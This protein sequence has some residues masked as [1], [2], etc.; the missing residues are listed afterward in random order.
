MYYTIMYVG[1]HRCPDTENYLL[2][3]LIILAAGADTGWFKTVNPRET[4]YIMCIVHTYICIQNILSIK[5]T[6]NIRMC[7]G[8][9]FIIRIKEQTDGEYGIYVKT[10][11]L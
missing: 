7:V 11:E 9:Y 3:L 5:R 2:V 4:L 1:R 8:L 6:I 10:I